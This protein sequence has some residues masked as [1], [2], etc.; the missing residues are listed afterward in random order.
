M[1]D[2]TKT[3]VRSLQQAGDTGDPGLVGSVGRRVKLGT[4]LAAVKVVVSG[5]TAAAAI[6]ITSSTVAAKITSLK[7]LDAL[8]T[9]ET[10]PPI[11]SVLALRV[12]TGSAQAGARTLVDKDGTPTTGVATISDDGKTLT[13][14]TTLTG[15]ILE[16]NPRVDVSMDTEYDSGV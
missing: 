5:L 16:Y 13:F 8:G 12:T 6:D 10:L 3:K 7:G 14:E 11:G 2:S 15:F 4:R 9:G 1:S